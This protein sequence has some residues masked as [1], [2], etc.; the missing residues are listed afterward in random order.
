M[1]KNPKGFYLFY[2]WIEDL[3]QLGDGD[4][5]WQIVKA[6]SEYFKNGKNPVEAVTGP[7]RGMVAVMFHQIRRAEDVSQKRSVA[8]RKGVEVKNGKKQIDN[9]VNFASAKV[10]YRVQNTEYS[11]IDSDT[12]TKNYNVSISESENA[13]TPAHESENDEPNLQTFG[14]FANVHITSA[15]Y[16][17][18]CAEY[19]TTVADELINRFSGKLQNKGYKYDDHFIALKLWAVEDNLKPVTRN[20]TSYDVEDFYLTA[21]SATQT[22]LNETR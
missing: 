2:D 12:I 9:Q 20:A 21:L 11:N 7:L 18:L 14:K 19:G 6:L 15:Q 17:E 1:I 10:S 22:T 3:D 13:Y 8:G 5:A 4:G 16:N